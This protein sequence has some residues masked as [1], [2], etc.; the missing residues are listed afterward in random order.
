MLRESEVIYVSH[1]YHR[2]RCSPANVVIV[3]GANDLT[4]KLGDR[5]A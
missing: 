1:V 3:S 4:G 2:V 5:F